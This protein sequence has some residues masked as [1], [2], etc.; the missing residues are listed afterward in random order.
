VPPRRS[1]G[2]VGRRISTGSYSLTYAAVQRVS[3][4]AVINDSLC[5]CDAQQRHRVTTVE[6][7]TP[8][9]VSHVS[10]FA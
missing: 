6:L 9:F 10:S 2:G 1:R 7:A 8:D 5:E 4:L 3:I